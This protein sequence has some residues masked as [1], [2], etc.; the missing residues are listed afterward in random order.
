MKIYRHLNGF[1]QRSVVLFLI[2]LAAILLTSGLHA[3]TLSEPIQ[4]LTEVKL[5]PG[6]IE[7]GK[8][9]FHDPRLSRDNSMSC[10]S[11]HNLKAGGVDRLRVSKGVNGGQGNINAPTVL[12]SGFNFSQ[13]W[14]GRAASL[15]DQIDG[16]VHNAVEMGSNWPDIIAKLKRDQNYHLNV[17][18]KCD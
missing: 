9:L 5:D 18:R 14:D 15:E 1:G 10:A 8:R 11:C 12:N 13:F 4:P 7:L 6:K 16:P 17:A 3:D 2:T